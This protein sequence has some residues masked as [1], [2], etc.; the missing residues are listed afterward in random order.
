[1]KK[2]VAGAVIGMALA[3]AS[4]AAADDIMVTKAPPP[5]SIPADFSWT[6]FYVGSHLGYAW[7]SSNWTRAARPRGSLNLFQPSNASTR[8]EASSRDCKPA[9][10]T[11][12]RTVSSSALKSMLRFRLSQI[13]PASPL[14]APRCFPRRR[15]ARRAL[16]RR[17]CRPARCAG[18]IGYAPGNWLFYATGGFAWTYDQ[19]TLTQ[20]AT[21]NDRVAL[22]VAT[23]LGGRR[24]RRV[25]GR[26]ALD[27]AARI[28]VHRLRHQQRDVP[29]RG[30]AR[31]IP[32]SPLQELR[33]GLNYQFGNDAT[34]ANAVATKAPATPDLDNL[35][36]HGQTTF[37]WQGYPAIPIALQRA[38]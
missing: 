34:P 33:A 5:S 29:G 32:I 19:L 38:Q 35:N 24:R 27:G 30:A 15:S 22:F 4:G 14:A 28:S 8:R 37:V 20:L 31:S 36:F 2:F 3:T 13:S 1:M 7:G 26:A 6:G 11:C 16:A 18:R 17:C 23:G 10:I 21:G 12:S 9:I 25:P